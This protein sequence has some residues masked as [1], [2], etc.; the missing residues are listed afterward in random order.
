MRLLYSSGPSIVP[1]YARHKYQHYSGNWHYA[2]YGHYWMFPS[3]PSGFTG[4]KAGSRHC[5]RTSTAVCTVLAV[6]RE[7][8]LD[9][10]RKACICRFGGRRESNRLQLR[11]V[12]SHRPSRNMYKHVC[13]TITTLRRVVYIKQGVSKNTFQE[14]RGM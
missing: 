10:F 4:A 11:Q 2:A 14:V 13:T 1:V 6:P 12:R 3:V 5:R 7:V 9:P 8:R